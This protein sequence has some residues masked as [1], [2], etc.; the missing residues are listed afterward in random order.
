MADSANTGGEVDERDGMVMDWSDL[1][2]ENRLIV[3]EL[4]TQEQQQQER[5]E[6]EAAVEPTDDD[7][8]RGTAAFL[9]RF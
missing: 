6:P 2:K 7:E 3:A 1:V 9:M 5:E 4:V 8:S